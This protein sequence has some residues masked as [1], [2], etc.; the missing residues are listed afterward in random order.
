MSP[1]P[2]LLAALDRAATSGARVHLADSRGSEQARTWAELRTAA[3]AFA[4]GLVARGVGPRERLLLVLGNGEDWLVAYLGCV[5]AGVLPVGISPPSGLGTRQAFVRRLGEVALD[6]QVRGALVP[7]ELREGTA[8]ALP[9]D[10]LLLDP[11]ELRAADPAGAPVRAIDLRDPAHLQLTSGTTSRSRAAVVTHGALAANLEQISSAT[12][13]GPGSTVVSWLPLFHDMG[14]VGGFLTALWRGVDL[15]LGTPFGFLRRP[16]S[17]LETIHRRRG[18][19]SPAPTFAYRFVADR[20]KPDE[21]AGL[22]LSSW[23][24][25]YVGAEAIPAGVLEAFQARLA[26]AGL[27]PTTL[28]PCYGLAETTVAV[29]FKP[30]DAPWR[31]ATV[32]RRGLAAEARARDPLEPGDAQRVVSCGRGLEP[33]ELELRDEAGRALEEDRVGR[34]WVR[35]PQCCAGYWGEPGPAPFDA[36]GWLDTGDLGF[37]RGGELHLVGRAKEVIILRGENHAPSE[38][39]WAAEQCPGVRRAAAFGLE[40]EREATEVL[41][42]LAEVERGA[43]AAAVAAEVKRRLLEET[44]LLVAELELIPAGQLP[45]TTSGKLQRALAREMFLRIRSERAPG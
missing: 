23:R 31:A 19:H 43:D 4:A 5:V 16:V 12:A 20:V 6:L 24:V 39:E 26:P 33:T 32:S 7:G 14:L 22:D 38:V 2:D 27:R 13:I 25:A 34:V 21:L 45:L 35:G 30:L 37:L 11:A 41:A 3:H 8:A 10:A 40:S 29:S 9:A 44:G 42:L 18:T 17:W 15:A 36:A 28:L 1:P